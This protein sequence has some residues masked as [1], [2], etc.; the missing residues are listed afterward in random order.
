MSPIT[1][2]KPKMESSIITSTQNSRIKRVLLLQQKSSERRQTGLFVVEGYR[3][4]CRCIDSGLVIEEVYRC[5]ELCPQPLPSDRANEPSVAYGTYGTHELQ[6]PH[7]PYT[8][9]HV[10]PT[11]YERMAYRGS[12]EGVIAVVRQQKLSLSDIDLSGQPLIMVLESVEK[13]GN[14]GAVLR[15][16]DA[17]GV[18]AVIVCDPLTDLCNPNLI[19]ASIGAFFSVPLVAC[20]SEECI[21]FLKDNGIAILTAQLQDSSLYYDTDMRRPVAIVMGTEATGLT[22]QW[23]K[24]A[25]AHI[26]IPMLGRQDSLNVSVS[27]AIL[28]FEAVRQRHNAL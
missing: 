24:A 22:P 27:A 18:T 23:R 15:S 21:A 13:P 28:L 7:N 2:K 17:A 9:F 4:L 16:A 1:P 26:R 14:L 12:T 20:S 10:S 25:D 19:R 6:K 8:T 5:P 3:E 11:V